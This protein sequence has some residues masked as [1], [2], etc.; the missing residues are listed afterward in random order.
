ME[1]ESGFFGFDGNRFTRQSGYY[2]YYEKN[3]QM[4]EFMLEKNKECGQTSNN[5]KPDVAMANFRKILKEKQEQNEKRKK[6]A[7][8]YGGKVVAAMVLFVGLVALRNKV[9]NVDFT[10]PTMIPQKIE[11]EQSVEIFHENVLVE[12][13]PGN[14]EALPINNQEEQGQLE[15]VWEE[16]E[17]EI[18][19]EKEM[20]ETV[21]YQEYI[22]QNGDTLAKISREFYGTDE[23]IWEICSLNGIADGDYI[24][25]GEIILLP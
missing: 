18:E 23:K 6:K 12:E 5:E 24:Q 8:S 10:E 14:V 13:L 25:V 21:D 15:E 11:E 2:I 20:E 7:I 3:E 4:R 17:Q 9:E 16:T 19:V 1:G 22:V